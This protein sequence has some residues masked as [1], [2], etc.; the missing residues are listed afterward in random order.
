MLQGI[1]PRQFGTIPKSSTTHALVNMTHNWLANTD[2]NGSTA[3]VVLLDFRKAFDLI[4]HSVL[5]QKLT[6]FAIPSQVKS[7]IVDFLM[8]RKQ[9]VK[10]AQDC[11]SEWRSVPS[12][13]PQGTKLGPWLFLVMIN[14]LDTPADMWKY[15]DDTSCSEIVRKGSESKLQEAVDDLSRQAS[16]DGFQLNEAKCKELRI[17]FSNNNHDFEPLVLNGK[18]LEVVTS[19]KLLGMI[20]SHDLKWNMHTSE[21]SRKCSSRLYFLRQLKRS[22][23]A[24]SELVLFYVTCIRPVLEYACP[25]FHRSLPNYIS[26][27]LERIQRRALRIIYPDLSYSVALETAGL[28]KL[29]ERREKISTDLF[30]EIVCDP[31]HRLHSLLPQ[32]KSCK[33]ALRRKSDFSL[34][35]CKTERLKNSFI[36][37]HVYKM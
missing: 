20:I 6:T 10:L 35:I 11:H 29:H 7:W 22:G 25:V 18:P 32:R 16:I 8:D 33:Y 13:V 15:V 19:A 30:D 14:D 34:P 2:G 12:G 27:D 3:R 28:P 23:V 1:D 31:T 24:P 4:D 9:R 26:E 5:V 17:G 36:F 37:S 21:L